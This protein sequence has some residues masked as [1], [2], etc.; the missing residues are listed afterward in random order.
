MACLGSSRLSL[1]EHKYPGR[2]RN[3]TLLSLQTLQR[4]WSRI[5]AMQKS[6]V[7][8]VQ[9][10]AYAQ[11]LPE[12]QPWAPLSAEDSGPWPLPFYPVLG[13]SPRGTWDSGPE[14]LSSPCW[15]LRWVYPQNGRFPGAQRTPQ[16]SAA[17][18]PPG[19]YSETPEKPEAPSRAG[20][21]AADTRRLT[22]PPLPSAQSPRPGDGPP[23]AE[24]SD[25]RAP[26]PAGWGR[27]WA[28]G[29][30]L[31]WLGRALLRVRRGCCPALCGGSAP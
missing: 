28:R 24:S 23:L 30:C 29:G 31:R 7:R 14:L 13:E 21:P 20:D 4:L 19:L 6:L 2:G 26:A 11:E 8:C 10:L 25:R 5:F 18:P 22:L 3:S 27:P 17:L 12:A 1:G 9:P 15:R 16:P